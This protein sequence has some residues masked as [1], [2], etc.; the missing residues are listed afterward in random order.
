MEYEFRSNI[1]QHRISEL[2]PF[3]IPALTVESFLG[4]SAIEIM[5]NRVKNVLITDN[6]VEKNL[7][8]IHDVFSI[9]SWMI[10]LRKS[11]CNPTLWFFSKI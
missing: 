4:F 6:A 7:K 9:V 2:D 3:D 1:V 10:S 5:P 11:W 8:I